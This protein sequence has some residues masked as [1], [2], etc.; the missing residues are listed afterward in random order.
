MSVPA[1][2]RSSEPSWHNP[3]KRY[4]HDVPPEYRSRFDVS[5]LSDFPIYEEEILP[6]SHNAIHRSRSL[7]RLK[8]IFDGK[9]PGYQEKDPSLS[10]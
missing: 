6:L 10:A 4:W 5:I 8:N 7:Q 9:D 2:R 1:L 3:F